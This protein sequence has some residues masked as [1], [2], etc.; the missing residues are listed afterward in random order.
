MDTWVSSGDSDL[1]RAAYDLS[2]CLLLSWGL[3]D[4]GVGGQTWTAPPG[5]MI[6]PSPSLLPLP[7]LVP[8]RLNI[9]LRGC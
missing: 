9:L 6:L 8:P 3:G 4:P 7:G 5:R 2:I 1:I